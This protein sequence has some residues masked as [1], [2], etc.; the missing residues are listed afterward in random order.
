MVTTRRIPLF[1]L[2]GILS[3]LTNITPGSVMGAPQDQIGPVAARPTCVSRA[4]ELLGSLESELYFIARSRFELEANPLKYCFLA[5]SSSKIFVQFQE[6]RKLCNSLNERLKTV[7]KLSEFE[8]QIGL[9]RDGVNGSYLFCS[10]LEGAPA[11]FELLDSMETIAHAVRQSQV[12]L[13][14]AFGDFV[15]SLR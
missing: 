4:L 14:D 11:L 1:Q 6:N 5:G 7:S 3:L 12:I 15:P 13:Q 2:A 8:V 9:M 10:Q